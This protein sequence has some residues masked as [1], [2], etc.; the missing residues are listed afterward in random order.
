[1]LSPAQAPAAVLAV[2]RAHAARMS[3]RRDVAMDLAQ[4]PEGLA[5]AL[6]LV[7]VLAMALLAQH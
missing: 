7:T 1:V 4:V 2:L 5:M 6:V 3:S